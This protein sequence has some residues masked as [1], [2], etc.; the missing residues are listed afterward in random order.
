MRVRKILAHGLDIRAT[1][2]WRRTS[3][4]AL[5][6]KEIANQD[7]DVDREKRRDGDKECLR[8]GHRGASLDR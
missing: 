1:S 3:S 8:G 7:Q 2:M 4:P 6:V 5:P